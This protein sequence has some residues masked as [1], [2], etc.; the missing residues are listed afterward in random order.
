MGLGVDG[1]R[2]GETLL[3]L[4]SQR[5]LDLVGDRP[6]N[7][8]LQGQNV[9]EVALE[10]FGPKVVLGARFDELHGRA[11]RVPRP[12]HRALEHHSTPSCLPIS[13]ID[14]PES[15][16]AITEVRAMTFSKAEIW[17]KVAISSS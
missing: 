3:L 6:R 15:L 9:G 10:A 2:S 5:Q 4:G 11:H 13:R 14:V 12:P 7:I 16:K 17:A 1:P 8:A